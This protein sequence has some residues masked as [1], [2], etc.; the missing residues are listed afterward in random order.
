MNRAQLVPFLVTVSEVRGKAYTHLVVAQ[1][2]RLQVACVAS[3]MAWVWAPP[4]EPW[5][6]VAVIDGV[7]QK[8]RAIQGA[9]VS[10]RVEQWERFRAAG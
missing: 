10:W 8:P 7:R 2:T 3:I 4:G 6:L 1:G 9:A 5:R